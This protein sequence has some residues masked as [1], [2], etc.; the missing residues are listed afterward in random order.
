MTMSKKNKTKNK[1]IFKISNIIFIIT[2]LI[3]IIFSYVL[4]TTNIIPNKYLI[5]A[6]ASLSIIFIGYLLSIRFK[7]KIPS[8]VLGIIVI[9]LSIIEIFA[10]FKFNDTTN[11]L[12]ENFGKSKIT[13]EYSLIVKN[14]SKYNSDKDLGNVEVLYYKDLDDDSKLKNKVN[15]L[16]IKEYD[17]NVTDML[18]LVVSDNKVVL[19]SNAFYEVMLDNDEK[20]ESNTK[21]IATFNIEV[22]EEDHNVE[23]NVTNDSFLLFINGIDT[24]SGKLPARSLSDVN[25]LMAVNPVKKEI[26]MV[27][28]PRDYYVQIHGTKGLKDKLT[29][30]GTFGGVKSTMATLEDLYELNIDYYIRVNF[31]MV[32]KLVDAIGG[33]TL[34]NDQNY[35][36]VSHVND[37]CVFKPGNNK[38]DGKCAL[39]F[40]RERYAYATGDKHRG[41]NQEQVITKVFEKISTSSTLIN[42]YSKILKALDG[43]FETS[44]EQ[45]DITSL[46]KMQIDDMAKW[47]INSYNVS[48]KGSME[49]THSYPKQKLYVM[50]EDSKTVETARTKLLEVLNK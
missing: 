27:A 32:I 9:I 14:D 21:V 4:I 20:Y 30:S 36:V 50:Y 38:V 41:E 29:H 25:I 11:F 49:Y 42:D 15:K 24:R 46:V 43:T 45:D 12:K 39:A 44:L 1:K 33:I 6:I 26:L 5:I 2:L 35:N 48:G 17:G 31:N 37:S 34:Y 23:K 10:I 47:T 19:V 40:A 7:K 8:I 16:N 28:T 22:D 3:S 18:S 13:Y